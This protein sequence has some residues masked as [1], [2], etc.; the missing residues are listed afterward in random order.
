MCC[1]FQEN[2]THGFSSAPPR[3]ADGRPPRRASRRAA[4]ALPPR[5]CPSGPPSAQPPRAP[6]RTRA[7]AG[8]SGAPGARRA[9]GRSLPPSRSQ[10]LAG[11]LRNPRRPRPRRL[12]A[13]R[14]PCCLLPFWPVN[15][16]RWR[17]L[18]RRQLKRARRLRRRGLRP[19]GPRGP[20]P[21]RASLCLRRR[22]P[23][24]QRPPRGLHQPP[25]LAPGDRRRVRRPPRRRGPL[26]R[27]LPQ[28]HLRQLLLLRPARSWRGGAMQGS[29]PRDFSWCKV[30]IEER[31]GK[32]Q[33]LLWGGLAPRSSGIRLYCGSGRNGL[34]RVPHDIPSAGPPADINIQQQ[35]THMSNAAKAGEKNR[36]KTMYGN[37]SSA[38]F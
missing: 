19:L 28:A 33:R 23:P 17:R 6:T 29:E 22:G 2:K 34:L 25:L 30:R 10:R 4:R 26:R 16:R 5:G 11:A 20:R 12:R 14:R 27:P 38:D 9:T 36:R 31:L 7:G 24:G 37:E 3:R 15:R 21:L 32:N 35:E 1:V 13:R 8:P 18:R